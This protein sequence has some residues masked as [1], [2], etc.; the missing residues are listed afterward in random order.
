[1]KHKHTSTTVTRLVRTIDASGK[2][3]EQWRLEKEQEAMQ[4]L[5]QKIAS[6]AYRTIKWGE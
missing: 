2:T 3:L 6:E 5:Q 4:Q 1:M